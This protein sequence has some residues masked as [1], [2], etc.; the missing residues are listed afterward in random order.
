MIAYVVI[1]EQNLVVFFCGQTSPVYFE[2]WS[3]LSIFWFV[4]TT[5]FDAGKFVFVLNTCICPQPRLD[6]FYGLLYT[7]EIL[8]L[9]T[10]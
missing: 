8:K 2:F 4:E 3:C 5:V 6:L 1:L 7:F 9:C 10:V